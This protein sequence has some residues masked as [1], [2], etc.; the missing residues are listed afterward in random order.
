MTRP[1]PPA[2]TQNEPVDPALGWQ[3]RRFEPTRRQPAI[4]FVHPDTQRTEWL[5]L[6]D[7]LWH[8]PPLGQPPAAA[9]LLGLPPWSAAVVTAGLGWQPVRIKVPLGL[10]D[11]RPHVPPGNPLT[12]PK[13]ELGRKLFFDKSYLTAQQNQSCASCHQ[14]D[15]GF[16]DGIPG[17][18]GFNTPT[19]LNVVYNTR[20]FWDGRA[21]YLEEVVQHTL[22]DE[23]EAGQPTRFRHV[24]GGAIGRL[25]GQLAYHQQFLEVFGTPPTQDALGRALATYLRTLLCGNSLVDRAR[26]GDSLRVSDFVQ[27]LDDAALRTLD[28]AGKTK[29]QVAAEL[30]E[31]QRLFF[32]LDSNKPANC[33]LC[34]SGANFTDDG[35]HN[36]G[37]GLTEEQAD[38]PLG[39]FAH[40]PVGHKDALLRGAFKTPT[41]RG[42]PRTGPYFHDGQTASLEEVIRFHAQ[43]GRWNPS[44]DPLLRE[45]N[46]RFQRRRLNLTEDDVRALA[47]FL[48]ALD[49]STVDPIFR[50]PPP[51]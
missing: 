48:R 33:A 35:F 32:N 12:L 22:E 14:P 4:E 13:W 45:P 27:I 9:S 25:K 30:H 51:P 28:R 26:H 2:Q 23:R 31:G 8:E 38:L 41:L 47:L 50:S 20:Q 15:L 42:L 6:P 19:L 43:G 5:Q 49:G 1:A 36:L 37:V 7:R 29:A 39:R 40:L 24:W 44:L 10:A 46:N 21:V 3:E 34:H 11:P 16:T 18:D 17:H